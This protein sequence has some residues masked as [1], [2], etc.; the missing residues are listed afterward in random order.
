MD[1]QIGRRLRSLRVERGWSLEELAISSG[2]SRGTLSRLENAEVSATTSALAKL[3]RVYDLTMSRLMLMIEDDFAPL[4]PADA[5]NVWTDSAHGFVRRGV[6]PPAKTLSGEI[7]RC[8]IAP[9]QTITYDQAPRPG[10]EHHLYV[11]QGAL[12]V[13]IGEQAYGLLTGDCLRY[14]LWEKTCFETGGLGVEYLVFL[15]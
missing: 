9:N 12:T 5:Q 14:Q 11:L 3:C 8:T 6:S 2:V 13:T 1:E 4:V 10:Q 15:I 7:I